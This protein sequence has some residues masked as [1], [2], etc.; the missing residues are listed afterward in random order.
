MK[1]YKIA[2]F[3]FLMMAFCSC[4]KVIHLNLGTSTSRYVIVGNVTDQPGPYT[5]SITKS[6]NFD[7]DN[8]FPAVSGA[9]VYITDSTAGITDTL[10]EVTPGN[11]QTHTIAGVSG[12]VYHL[13]VLVNGNSFASSSIM[14]QPVGLDSIYTQAAVF[15]N[16]TDVVPLYRDPV[17]TGNYYHLVLTVQDSVSQEIYIHD[18]EA[19]DGNEVQSALRNDIKVN[20]GNAI[21]VELQCIDHGVFQYFKDLQQTIQQNSAT[22]A[23]PESNITG[24]SLGYFSAHTVRKKT[25]IAQ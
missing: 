2:S 16:N 20:S 17:G 12:H 8:V 14:P 22:P 6:I 25:I 13:G 11:Y 9:S 1:P 10:T 21:T 5:I 15:G 18:D 19:T 3:L 4:Q 24:G 23:N 7:Q